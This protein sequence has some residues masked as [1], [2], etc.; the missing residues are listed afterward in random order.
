M[1]FFPVTSQERG[2]FN[3]GINAS[4][5][6]GIM[7]FLLGTALLYIGASK[8]Y[9]LFLTLRGLLPLGAPEQTVE[10][11]SSS[12]PVVFLYFVTFVS[13]ISAVL[14]GVV[15]VFSGLADFFRSGTFNAPVAT[16]QGPEAV[17]DR[18]FSA[19]RICDSA[20]SLPQVFGRFPGGGL[21][22]SPISKSLLKIAIVS[23]FKIGF[24][25]IILWALTIGIEV[26]PHFL[27]QFFTVQVKFVSPSFDSIH[28]LFFAALCFNLLVGASLVS[29]RAPIASKQ[30]EVA[31]LEGNFAAP[32][33]LSVF[34]SVFSLLSPKGVASP[35]PFRVRCGGI[36][37][38]PASLVESFPRPLASVSNPVGFAFIPLAFFMSIWG[39]SSLMG[40]S[41]M[42]PH[43]TT[44][45]FLSARFP[46]LV[47]DI[48]FY[49][50][51]IWFGLHVAD[52]IR[53]LFS[54]KRYESILALCAVEPSEMT[55]S[56]DVV[57]KKGLKRD[58]HLASVLEQGPSKDLLV[59]SKAPSKNARFTASVA[60]SK[61]ITESLGR[62]SGR[63]YCK[64]V[65]D[66][67]VDA[68]VR[69]IISLTQ[70]IHVRRIE[71]LRD[72]GQLHRIADEP[73]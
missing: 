47:A 51:M 9:H 58:S 3:F 5:F 35:I 26:A 2:F 67:D 55:R 32:V 68:L 28:W 29:R 65:K 71:P 15:W 44:S 8:L 50:G 23:F 11:I 33:Y 27:S 63:F 18:F 20:K 60:W 22:Y 64:D 19:D 10:K 56:M 21:S 25:W 1:S 39:F 7:F 12:W 16:L 69:K 54:V 57:E 6:Y 49:I 61:V 13:S 36:D 66:P 52:W 14:F 53:I 17:S 48:F 41:S 45:N 31:S 24:I 38:V 72:E 42:E 30:S 40:F 62:S 34:E 4:S 37:G 70:H 59:W 73:E 46:F 43:I